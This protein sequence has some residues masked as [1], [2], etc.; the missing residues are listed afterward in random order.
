MK[1]IDK[2]KLGLWYDANYDE[3]LNTLRLK[4][5]DLCFELNQTRPS[6]V[7]KRHKILKSLIFDLGESVTILSCMIP[8]SLV[9]RI[10]RSFS[11]LI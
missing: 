10:I 5:D 11:N 6:E 8:M 4:A 7:A 9:Y 1:A 3:D 2:M